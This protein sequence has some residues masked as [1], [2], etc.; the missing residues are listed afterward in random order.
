MGPASPE[1]EIPK[2]DLNRDCTPWAISLT[3]SSLTA[4]NF[5]RVSDLYPPHAPG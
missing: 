3:V 2:S 4:P 5:S 1:M